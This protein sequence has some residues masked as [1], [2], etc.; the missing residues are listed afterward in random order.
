MRSG[1]DVA[2]GNVAHN[3]KKKKLYLEKNLNLNVFKLSN[4]VHCIL[5]LNSRI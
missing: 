5:C 4:N 3:F 1:V 2:T